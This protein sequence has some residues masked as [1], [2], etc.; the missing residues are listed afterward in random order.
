MRELLAGFVDLL[1][2]P[3]CAGCG[4]TP[5]RDA[6]LCRDC[7]RLLP[8]LPPGGC[9]RCQAVVPEPLGHACTARPG[10]LAACVAE[11]AFAVE[12]AEWV[13]RFKYAPSGLRGL[14]PR[15]AAVVQ[16]LVLAA[17]RRLPP[18]LPGRIVPV[19][20]HPR[21]LRERGF[22][23]A[24]ELARPLARRLGARFEPRRLERTR[25]TASQ[26]GLDRVARERNVAGAFRARG[27]IPPRVCVALVDD[28][29]TTGATLVAAA[30]ALRRAGARRVVAVC[31][32]R[33][34]GA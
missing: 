3:A 22:H 30:R 12:A 24:A 15:P 27:R 2:P 19:P 9:V 34:L 18:P 11:V 20:L 26:T 23:P 8:R 28:V 16:E 13:R 1:L 21:R 17:A 31:A 7:A 6:A 32:A 14:D 10:V 33:T 29:V 5:P 4:R 25:D